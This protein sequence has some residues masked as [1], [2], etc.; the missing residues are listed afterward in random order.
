MAEGP[1]RCAWCG[2]DPAYVRYHDTE[3]GVPV[4]DDDRLFE[5][6][7]LEGFQAG[8][9]WRTILH[10]RQRFR[11]VFAGF[12]IASVARFAAADVE[13]LLSDPG[14]VRHRGKIEAT[15]E[16]ARLAERLQDEAGSLA[17][18]VWSFEPDPST[19]PERFDDATLAALTTSPAAA[20]LSR[21]LKARGWRFVGPTT[22]Y[23]FMQAMGL[24][25]DH[26]EACWRRAPVAA[27]R[28]DLARPVPTGP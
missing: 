27:L 16:N 6:L 3:W 12:S 13:R 5:K 19:R 28:R 4:V 24:V 20:A 22:V 21:T 26:H 10:K 17:A 2:D 15:I 23:A 1:A 8:L 14:I 18:F 11:E 9:S 25:N 7:A